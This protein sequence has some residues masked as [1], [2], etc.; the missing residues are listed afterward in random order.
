MSCKGGGNDLTK[1]PSKLS[2]F[3]SVTRM[4]R[5]SCNSFPKKAAKSTL[6]TSFTFLGF[7]GISGGGGI[8]YVCSFFPSQPTCLLKS[9]CP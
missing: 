9:K 3:Y 5:D 7:D 8:S 6:E 1:D 4:V 2:L